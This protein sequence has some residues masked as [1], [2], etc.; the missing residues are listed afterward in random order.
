MATFSI[1]WPAELP[2]NVRREGFSGSSSSAILRTGMDAGYPLIRRRY[3]ANTRVWNIAMTMTP[4]EFE[5]F[6]NFF[7]NNPTHPTLPG[8]WQGS[9][10]IN[11]PNPIWKPGVSQTEDDRPKVVCRFVIPT[12][13]QSYTYTPD[14]TTSD[15]IVSF[16]L[17]RLPNA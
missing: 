11:F 7:N 10:L 12:G 1:D 14:G 6:E 2:Q 16:Q 3:T 13:G 4:E 9:V 15:W 5:Y 8:I 17:E